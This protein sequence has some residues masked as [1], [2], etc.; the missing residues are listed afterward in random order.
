MAIMHRVPRQ[1]IKAESR[2][3]SECAHNVTSQFG[4]DGILKR[5][6][7]IMP[8]SSKW[9]VE[10][11][12]W[13]GKYL[14]N[15][16]TLIHDQG[17]S[18]VLIEGEEERA[19]KL[20]SESL[21]LDGRVHV[22]QAFVGWDGENAL[23]AIL[24]TTPVPHEFDLL[25]IDVDGNDWHI[26]SALERYRPR[27]VVIEHN[28]TAS[29]QLYFVQDADPTVS[30]GCSLLAAVELGR[31][32]GYELVA[33][34]ATNGIFVVAEEFS[35]FG[36]SDNSIDAMHPEIIQTEICFGY[37]GTVIAAGH[38]MVH[39]QNI[40]LEQADFQVLPRHA[41]KYSYSG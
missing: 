17:W 11:G 20:A 26:W 32:K 13:D 18:A 38:M 4:E 2:V 23:D 22:K 34:T 25:S 21:A 19:S 37:D 40:P 10:F 30:Q 33:T 27:V 9:C 39:W 14:S 1:L 16:W 8:P 36:I 24:G 29:N 12:A 3:L 7:E 5:I 6:F 41:R 28:P 35:R 15:T 31:Q